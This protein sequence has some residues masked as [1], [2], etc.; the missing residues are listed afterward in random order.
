MRRRLAT[1]T[2]TG[3]AAVLLLAACAAP[4]VADEAAPGTAPDTDGRDIALSEVEQNASAESCW[5]AID[6]DVFDLTDW[7]PQHPG[8]A[9]R[10]EALCGTDG[11]AQFEGQHGGQGGP[12]SQLEEYRIGELAD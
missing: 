2:L 6:G 4:D 9:D 12:E 1:T 10:I 3:L 11:T 8:G 5:V 7:I